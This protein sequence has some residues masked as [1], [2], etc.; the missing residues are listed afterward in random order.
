MANRQG[1][2]ITRGESKPVDTFKIYQILDVQSNRGVVFEGL[3]S[4]KDS[5]RGVDP[6][7]YS[8]VYSGTLRENTTLEDLFE[9]FNLYR[10]SGY[11]ARSM[12]VSDV[13]VLNRN[14]EDKAYFCDDF[15][16]AEVPEFLKEEGA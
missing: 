15:G 12:S 16:F 10:P 7:I 13:V 9:A 3:K 11:T 2:A 4:L 14:G 1:S 6:A 5:G 8:E